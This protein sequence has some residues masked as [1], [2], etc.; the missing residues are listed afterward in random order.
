MYFYYITQIVPLEEDI[1]IINPSLLKALVSDLNRFWDGGYALKIQITI[2][3]WW[4]EN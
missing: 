2:V 1:Y 3:I 4:E